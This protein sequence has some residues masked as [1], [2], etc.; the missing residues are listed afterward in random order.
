MVQTSFFSTKGAAACLISFGNMVLYACG[1]SRNPSPATAL[2]SRD[3]DSPSR[4]ILGQF[5]AISSSE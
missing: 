3:M 1:T 4:M 2:N 5:I